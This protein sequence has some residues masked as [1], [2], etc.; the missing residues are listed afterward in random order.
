MPWLPN[1]QS[2]KRRKRVP[3]QPVPVSHL[4]KQA[5]PVIDGDISVPEEPGLG[6]GHAADDGP[7]N[8]RLLSQRAAQ[9]DLV[10]LDLP[11]RFSAAAARA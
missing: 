2:S 1:E 6:M 9:V 11:E 5:F 10:R 8:G 4:T 7:A 3:S